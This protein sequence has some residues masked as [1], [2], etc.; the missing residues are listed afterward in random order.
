MG[1]IHN[2]PGTKAKL[3]EDLADLGTLMNLFTQIQ[4]EGQETGQSEEDQRESWV[5]AG[6]WS[7][8]IGAT[9]TFVLNGYLLWKLYRNQTHTRIKLCV[10]LGSTSKAVT[11]MVMKLP[12]APSDYH[13]R[14]EGSPRVLLIV[15]KWRPWLGF[16]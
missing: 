5:A 16:D 12:G 14:T 3:A 4:E 13:I 15:G 6:S 1:A 10:K 11:L 2:V 9:G 7:T 8:I